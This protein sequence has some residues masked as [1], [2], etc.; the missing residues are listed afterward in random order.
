MNALIGNLTDLDQ[1]EKIIQRQKKIITLLDSSRLM[2][3]A[4]ELYGKV[5]DLMDTIIALP[6]GECPDREKILIEIL[7]QATSMLQR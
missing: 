2:K 4:V 6:E 7:D 5:G 1:A 3:D